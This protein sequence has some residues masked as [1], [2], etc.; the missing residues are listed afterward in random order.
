MCRW[1][2]R[3]GKVRAIHLRW[4]TGHRSGDG[5]ERSSVRWPNSGAGDE[6]N[7]RAEDEHRSS[8]PSDTRLA[9]NCIWNPRGLLILK[10]GG[11][12]RQK[13]GGVWIVPR[14]DI[15]KRPGET[16]YGEQSNT[17]PALQE[18]HSTQTRCGKQEVQRANV[19]RRRPLSCQC[20]LSFCCFKTTK[21]EQVC[22]D[23][24]GAGFIAH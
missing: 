1:G 10:N 6:V 22:R 15:D 23:K 11:C 4:W 2:G 13:I 17:C 14:C 21:C 16:G 20:H 19:R 8:V 9:F 5:G 18:L 24:R 7:R 12:W 3:R